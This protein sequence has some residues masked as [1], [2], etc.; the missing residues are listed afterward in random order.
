MSTPTRFL[1][2]MRLEAL[3]IKVGAPRA[4][5][6]AFGMGNDAAKVVVAKLLRE[7]AAPVALLGV[8][9]ALNDSL[10]PGDVVVASEL[11]LIG[12][13][14]TAPI[15]AADEVAKLL[16]S[17]GISAVT[18]PIT[19][20][21]RIVSGDEAREKAAA[22]GAVAVDME[23]WFFAPLARVGQLIV[24]RTIIDVPGREVISLST[25]VAA[26]HAARALAR[27]A[28]AIEDR[29]ALFETDICNDQAGES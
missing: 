8:S 4:R 10:A 15:A 27:V 16:D 28:G 5:V 7:S 29:E 25:P 18:G 12:K 23:S 3:A 26:W 24:I 13:D 1:A 21:S 6:R 9:G 20:A 17:R 11:G 2:A 22:G 14:E 19:T